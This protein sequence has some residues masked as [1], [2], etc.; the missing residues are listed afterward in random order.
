VLQH[1]HAPIKRKKA[2][3]IGFRR[4][5]RP[6]Y[7]PSHL[8]RFN[9]THPHGTSKELIKLI[10]FFYSI[11]SRQVKGKRS[12]QEKDDPQKEIPNKKG[13]WSGPFICF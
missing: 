2:T 5:K 10:L 7:Y 1:G 12:D 9:F 4:P 3:P 13:P 11:T 6:Y 8:Q